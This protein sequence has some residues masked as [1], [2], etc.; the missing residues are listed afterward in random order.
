VFVVTPEQTIAYRGVALGPIVDG[1]RVVRTGLN[2]GDRVVV[3]GLQR[4]RPGV[5]VAPTLVAMDESQAGAAAGGPVVAKRQ[6]RETR[7]GGK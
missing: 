2:P 7:E 1:L 6:A 5:K 3:N 4:V